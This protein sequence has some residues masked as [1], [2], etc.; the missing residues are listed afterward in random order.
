MT[1]YLRNILAANRIESGFARILV[2]DVT[3][4]LTRFF[5]LS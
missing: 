2:D 5:L 3:A 1:V 4:T